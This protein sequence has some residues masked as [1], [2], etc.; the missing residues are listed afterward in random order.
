VIKHVG[1]PHKRYWRYINRGWNL[2]SEAKIK[3]DKRNRQ[4]VIYLTLV[5]E[6]EEHKPR[7][8]LSVDVNENNVTMLVDGVA[9]LF[10]TGSEELVLGYYYR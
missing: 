10:E 3:L 5:K 8:L 6:I 2:A 1:G 9:H 4:L 7:G